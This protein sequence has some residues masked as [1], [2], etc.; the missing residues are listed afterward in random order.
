MTLTLAQSVLLV[1]ASAVVISKLDPFSL[2][3]S[4]LP[5]QLPS[6]R[7][8]HQTPLQKKAHQCSTFFALAL[9]AVSSCSAIINTIQA[10]NIESTLG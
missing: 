1:D 9:T 5:L 10:V 6:M 8:V 4:S 7:L 3:L 2:H